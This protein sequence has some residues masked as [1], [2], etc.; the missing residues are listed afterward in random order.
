VQK[1]YIVRILMNCTPYQILFI[2]QIEKNGM[3]GASCTYGGEKSCIQGFSGV[4]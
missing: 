1:T 3:Y 4:M 2:D